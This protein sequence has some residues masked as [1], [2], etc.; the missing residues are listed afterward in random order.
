M[1]GGEQVR[2]AILALFDASG[3]SYEHRVHLRPESPQQ[4]ASLRGVVAE[5]MTKTLLL[6]VGEHCGLYTMPYTSR[7]NSKAVRKYHGARKAHFVSAEVLLEATGLVP[8]TVPPVGRPVLDFQLFADPALLGSE[9]IA[10]G[11]GLGTESLR[12]RSED[13]AAVVRPQFFD[14]AGI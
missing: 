6:R 3:V 5:A 11:V 12:V 7:M 13:W 10:F 1:T 9:V 14:F 4:A 2:A 8:G